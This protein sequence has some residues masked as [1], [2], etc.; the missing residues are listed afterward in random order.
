MLYS[1]F[2]YVARPVVTTFQNMWVKNYAVAEQYIYQPADKGVVIVG[3]SM[4]AKLPADGLRTDAYN[5]SF[6][7]GSAITGL[8]IIRQSGRIP[9]AIFIETNV[10]ERGLNDEML[11][12]L[13]T[14]LIWRLKGKLVSLQYTY[15]PINLLLSLIKGYSMQYAVAGGEE[16]PDKRRFTIG[17]NK[18]LVNSQSVVPLQNNTLFAAIKEQVHFFEGQGTRVVFFQ[19]PVAGQLLASPLYRA[20]K[21]LLPALFPSN[22]FNWVDAAE[23][24]KYQTT[25]GVHLMPRSAVRYVDILNAYISR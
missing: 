10:L 22:Q 17:L 19:M 3:S 24:R 7:G 11:S 6:V 18:Q 1:L 8:S 25:D 16:K 9:V 13:F 4:A 12:R 14:P 5:L 20:R 2:L 15:Q 21:M 23:Q